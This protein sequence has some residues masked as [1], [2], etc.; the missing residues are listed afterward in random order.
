V[1]AP[2]LASE[3][4][5][6]INGGTLSWERTTGETFRHYSDNTYFDG[7]DQQLVLGYTLQKSRRMFFDFSR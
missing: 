7:I 2:K 4:T 6:L 1:R 3:P 5:G